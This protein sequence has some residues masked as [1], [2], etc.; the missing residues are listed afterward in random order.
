MQ[1]LDIRIPSFYNMYNV[2]NHILDGTRTLSLVVK[3]FPSGEFVSVL[4]KHL[5]N[6]EPLPLYATLTK[7]LS[8][9]SLMVVTMEK[10][11]MDK[12]EYFYK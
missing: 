6:L 4:S 7:P 1:H 12:C 11:I 3:C 5:L 10:S 9:I 2:N 8:Y